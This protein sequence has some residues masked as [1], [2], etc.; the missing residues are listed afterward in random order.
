MA[1]WPEKLEH[2][3]RAPSASSRCH[4]SANQDALAK[5]VKMQKNPASQ[6]APH[7]RPTVCDT[8][9]HLSGVHVRSWVGQNMV[10]VDWSF[11]SIGWSF[12]SN[13]T[14]R[15]LLVVCV[16]PNIQPSHVSGVPTPSTICN[17][18]SV[19]DYK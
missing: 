4:T 6:H 10:Q 18:T 12:V 16:D 19:M 11:I 7:T 14:S 3:Q 8:S 1:C 13:N 5:K 2:P 17:L 9:L 15:D